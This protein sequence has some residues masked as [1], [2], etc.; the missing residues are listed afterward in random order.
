[1]PNRSGLKWTNVPSPYSYMV[2]W[3]RDDGLGVLISSD[4]DGFMRV[5]C[6]RAKK[7]PTNSDVRAVKRRFLYDKVDVERADGLGIFE[8]VVHFRYPRAGND[9]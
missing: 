4:D 7:R 1:M 3:K 9:S 8:N 5:S 6:S 2:A